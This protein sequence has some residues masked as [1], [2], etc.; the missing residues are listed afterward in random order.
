MDLSKKFVSHVLNYFSQIQIAI[1]I[2]K[3]VDVLSKNG[4]GN[5]IILFYVNCMRFYNAKMLRVFSSLSF[6]AKQPR[7][8]ICLLFSLFSG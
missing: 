8:V 7:S 6:I 3:S 5:I 4:T 2:K 1:K